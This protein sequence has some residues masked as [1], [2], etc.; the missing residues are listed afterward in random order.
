MSKQYQT[1]LFLF[2]RDLRINDNKALLQACKQ[3]ETVI[4]IF[5]FDPEQISTINS[6]KSD[7]A[8][9]FMLESLKDLQEQFK[10][11]GARLNLFYGKPEKTLKELVTMLS[12]DALFFNEDYT[13]FALAR[14]KAI[15]QVM[16]KFSVAVH[17]FQGLLL[18]DPK[19]LRNQ[20]GK[21]Y[22]VFTPFFNKA[23]EQG[24]NEPEKNTYKNFY[25]KKI[26]T[27]FDGNQNLFEKFSIA[28]NSA[29]VVHGGTEQAEKILNHVD[30]FKQYAK[31]RDFPFLVTTHLSAHLKFGTVSP[32]QVIHSI[33]EHKA[34]TTLIRQLYWRDF[35][36]HIAF[37]F[38]H[39][40]GKAFNQNYQKVS[41]S[42]NK[43][44][45][46]QWC[47]GQTGFP[48]VD[49]GMRQL[50][51][52][53]YMH[54]RVRMIVCS[55]LTK[56]LH[57]DWQWGEKYFAQKLVDYDPAVNNGSWQ[58]GASTGADAAPYFRV[59]NPWL[60]QK[61]FD[62]DCVYIKQ[63]V[64]ELRLI[65]TKAIHNYFNATQ[66]LTKEYP[67]PM[68]DHA[69]TSQQAKKMFM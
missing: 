7:N 63:W 66:P 48:I 6:Y 62:A 26:E 27:A 40:F 57:I 68:V 19:T 42:H 45:F 24:I 10:S 59:F 46:E 34:D 31:T 12:I 14:D 41:W 5:I 38:P 49:A 16:E 3:A 23:T 47:N 13:P 36:T 17:S 35:Y 51:T 22:T 28:K 64:P 9:Q 1:A 29:I 56:N 55:F 18:T 50:N 25:T 32:Q 60:Q 30:A 37:H 43:K 61:K 8:I 2:H 21:P 44:A 54:N 53:G 15:T 52:T 20:S 65:Q 33:K 58:W 4:P 69:T 11:R 67:L 39:V